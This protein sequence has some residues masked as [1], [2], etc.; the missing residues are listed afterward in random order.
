[1]EEENAA[2]KNNWMTI[3]NKRKKYLNTAVHHYLRFEVLTT[4][5][6]QSKFFMTADTFP[7]LMNYVTYN[8]QNVY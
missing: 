3:M 1:V 2:H 8:C 5:R 4:Q 6:P 7:F